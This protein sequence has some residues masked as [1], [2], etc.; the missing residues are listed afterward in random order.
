MVPVDN[1]ARET[2][3][4]RQQGGRQQAHCRDHRGGDQGEAG[5]GAG[6]NRP[7]G[8]GRDGAFRRPLPQGSH[9]RA[10]RHAVAAIVRTP[11]LSARTGSAPGL[12]PRVHPRSGQADAGTGRQDRERRHQGGA[13]G[14]VPSLQAQASHPRRDRPRARAGPA[15]RKHPRRPQPRSHRDR[16]ILRAGRGGRREG[17]ARRRARHRRGRLR[18]ERRSSGRASR[19]YEGPGR[20]ALARGR[21]QGSGR[22][23]ILGL[24]RPFR[25]LGRRRRPPGAGHAARPQRGLSVA[26]H[27][28]GRRRPRAGEARRTQDRRRL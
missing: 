18:R 12:D 24:F 6:R 21:G 3:G 25:T 28:G 7:S 4:R 23:E 13:G 8:R 11:R 16:Q 17:R 14:P 26:R 19:L 27:R 5:T 15:G 2:H 1:A 10:G 20:A 22:R 9:R